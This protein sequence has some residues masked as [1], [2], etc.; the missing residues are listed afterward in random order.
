MRFKLLSVAVALFAVT[1]TAE[2]GTPVAPT[3]IPAIATDGA[4]SAIQVDYRCRRGMVRTPSGRC[5]TDRRWRDD[6][7]GWDRHSPRYYRERDRDRRWR[8]DRDHRR[9]RI[10]IEPRRRGPHN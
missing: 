5:V 6:R 3:P 4:V 2:A 10:Y 1:A 9:E 8:R 7:R